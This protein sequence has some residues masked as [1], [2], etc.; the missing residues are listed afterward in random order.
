MQLNID[1][2]SEV[3]R[4]W[5]SS[6]LSWNYWVTYVK[7]RRGFQGSPR[8]SHTVYENQSQQRKKKELTTKKMSI[9]LRFSMV[10]RTL[11]WKPRHRRAWGSACGFSEEIQV[12]ENS[13]KTPRVHVFTWQQHLVS[14][15]WRTLPRRHVSTFLVDRQHLVSPC[16]IFS[17]WSVSWVKV[18]NES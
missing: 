15:F 1:C 9:W 16:W 4:L 8:Y 11:Q 18:W 14:P 13:A 12:F 10:Y 6:E 7:R 17:G 2:L 3:D 5:H